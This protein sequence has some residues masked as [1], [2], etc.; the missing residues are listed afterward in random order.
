[1]S[2]ENQSLSSKK[3]EPK[4]KPTRN[5]TKLDVEVVKVSQP[6]PKAEKPKLVVKPTVFTKPKVTKKPVEVGYS[7]AESAA[8]EDSQY[9][10][11]MAL[12]RKVL[13]EDLKDYI[14][15]AEANNQLDKQYKVSISIICE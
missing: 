3:K 12:S 14:A 6:T 9:Y 10:N 1:M 7:T 11:I 8:A 2:H 13:K 5:D 4:A 15:A